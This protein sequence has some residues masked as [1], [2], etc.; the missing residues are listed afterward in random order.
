MLE[1]ELLFSTFRAYGILDIE[2]TAGLSL[3]SPFN[4]DGPVSGERPVPVQPGSVSTGIDPM[5]RGPV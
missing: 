3:C 2:G 4:K 1:T 5:H